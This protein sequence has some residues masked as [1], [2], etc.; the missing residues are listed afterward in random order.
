MEYAPKLIQ[1]FAYKWTSTLIPSLD[2]MDNAVIIIII[3]YTYL[4]TD[5]KDDQEGIDGQNI[6]L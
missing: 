2:T 3:L 6:L 1:P 5:D 4:R